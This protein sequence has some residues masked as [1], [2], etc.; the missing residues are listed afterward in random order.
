MR[1]PLGSSEESFRKLPQSLNEI[2]LSAY[3]HNIPN[4]WTSVTLLSLSLSLSLKPSR[5]KSTDA[6][7]GI[8]T[9]DDFNEMVKFWTEWNTQFDVFQISWK[10]VLNLKNEVARLERVF[11]EKQL[12]DEAHKFSQMHAKLSKRGDNHFGE[13]L[14]LGKRLGKASQKVWNF[15]LFCFPNNSLKK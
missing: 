1:L 15:F 3:S 11:L 5:K 10:E 2:A 4:A 9:E 6:V 12:K 13:S 14:S 7:L 8:G